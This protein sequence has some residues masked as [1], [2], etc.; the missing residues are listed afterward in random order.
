MLEELAPRIVRVV[1][2]TCLLLVFLVRLG[3]ACFVQCHTRMSVIEHMLKRYREALMVCIKGSV[4]STGLLPLRCL[5]PGGDEVHHLDRRGPGRR[6]SVF[7]GGFGRAMGQK[8]Y[9]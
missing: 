5:R 7:F 3:F 1:C 4:Y 6:H 2:F 8:D 9:A